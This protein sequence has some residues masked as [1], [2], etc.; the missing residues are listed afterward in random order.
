MSQ[1]LTVSK[2]TSIGAA[3]IEWLQHL[4][5]SG[6]FDILRTGKRYHRLHAFRRHC[7]SRGVYF[8]S[9]AGHDEMRGYACSG[10][11]KTGTRADRSSMV[12]QLV[13]FAISRGM[14]EATLQHPP[15]DRP[16]REA[17]EPTWPA[18]LRP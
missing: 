2:E 1:G 18:S 3:C 5:W 11:A 7:N 8:I 6:R 10:R 16:Q 17:Y 15:Q 14:R 9:N 13:D 12:L 4:C